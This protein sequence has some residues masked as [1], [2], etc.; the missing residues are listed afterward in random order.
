MTDRTGGDRPVLN[1]KG[2]Y[3]AGGRVW[4]EIW[5]DCPSTEFESSVPGRLFNTDEG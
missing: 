2:G 3:F 4:D 5:K 1:V